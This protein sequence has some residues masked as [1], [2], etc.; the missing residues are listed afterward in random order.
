MS[1][2][3]NIEPKVFSNSEHGALRIGSHNPAVFL[4]DQHEKSKQVEV[5]ATLTQRVRALDSEEYGWDPV[6]KLF[7]WPDGSREDFMN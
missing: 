4:N 2:L 5:G 3:V 6:R 1:I 7:K